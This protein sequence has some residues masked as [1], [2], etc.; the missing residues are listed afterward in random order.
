MKRR[1]RA[2][3]MR[4]ARNKKRRRGLKKKM[5]SPKSQTITQKHQK[6]QK[7]Q[8]FQQRKTM[9]MRRRKKVKIQQRRLKR[10]QNLFQE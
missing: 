9:M 4:I 6:H 5:I 7:F 1:R 3:V 10:S 8:R 2:K